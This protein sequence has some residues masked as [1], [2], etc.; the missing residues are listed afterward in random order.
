MS[1][2]Y[3]NTNYFIF[4]AQTFI[5][6]YNRIIIIITPPRHIYIFNDYTYMSNLYMLAYTKQLIQQIN[7]TL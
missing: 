1:K 5:I 4:L 2:N 6:R 3:N 7:M